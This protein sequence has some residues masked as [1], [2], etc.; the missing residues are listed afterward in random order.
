M[1]GHDAL[2][3]TCDSEKEHLPLGLPDEMRRH[4]DRVLARINA[5]YECLK[6]KVGS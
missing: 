2:A 4:A 5:G 1:Q 6:K 3:R